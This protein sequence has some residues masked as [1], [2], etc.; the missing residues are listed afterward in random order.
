ME[1]KHKTFKIPSAMKLTALS[2]AFSL[3]AFSANVEAQQVSVSV[4]D[5]NVKT[6]LNEISQQTGLNL[7][8][9]EQVIDMNRKVTL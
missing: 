8:Y 7:A 2:L 3:S 5:A 4:T 1:E 9:S 6:V